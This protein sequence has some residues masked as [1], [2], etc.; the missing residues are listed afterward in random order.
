ML[1]WHIIWHV[2]DIDKSGLQSHLVSLASKYRFRRGPYKGFQRIQ[3]KIPVFSENNRKMHYRTIEPPTTRLTQTDR[4]RILLCLRVSDLRFFE[5]VARNYILC[6]SMRNNE[7][8]FSISILS[9]YEK[10]RIYELNLELHNFYKL[11]AYLCIRL[12]SLLIVGREGKI[13]RNMMNYSSM[14]NEGG[15]YKRAVFWKHFEISSLYLTDFK[16]K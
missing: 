16:Y 14:Y 2:I 9:Q 13:K 6:Y 15:N 8:N 12:I 1:F 7:W 5:Q 4:I 10:Y 3:A 11:P